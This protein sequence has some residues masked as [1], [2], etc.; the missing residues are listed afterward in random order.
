MG[1]GDSRVLVAKYHTSY[2]VNVSTDVRRQIDKRPQ[3]SKIEQVS[4][5]QHERVI[6][7]ADA[8]AVSSS[9]FLPHLKHNLHACV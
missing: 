4:A 7:R 1:L 3:S 9:G 8:A 2:P 6:L 5:C